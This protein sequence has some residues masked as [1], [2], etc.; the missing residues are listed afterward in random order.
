MFFLSLF[1]RKQ[2]N[3]LHR[4][5]NETREIVKTIQFQQ[6][7]QF[8]VLTRRFLLHFNCKDFSASGF[9]HRVF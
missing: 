2:T 8:H 6:I 3:I 4:E 1:E 7:I 5:A 9:L